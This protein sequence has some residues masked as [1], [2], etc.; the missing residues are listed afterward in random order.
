MTL[1][2]NFK[3]NSIEVKAALNK[4]TIG[5]LNEWANEIASHAKRNCAMD[6]DIGPQLRGSYRADVYSW[7]GRA[8]VGSPMEA[9]LW[10]EFGTGSYAENGKGR[11]GWWVY[12]DDYEGNGGKQRTEEQAKAIAAGDPKLHATN[13]RP[14]HH[15]LETAFTVK[16]PKALADLERKLK[17]SMG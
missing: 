4:T 3:D 9:S 8:E 2:V 13:G 16:K 5:W 15:T 11:K 6:G 14:P 10:E 12:S 17:G 1:A 7:E